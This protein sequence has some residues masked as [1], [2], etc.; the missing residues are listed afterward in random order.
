M[1]H[2]FQIRGIG[3]AE[4]PMLEGWTTLGF[5]AANTS[6][7]R[8]GLMVG[9]IHYRLPGLW[10]K[11]AT[12][13]DVLSGGRA[14]LGIGAAW[15]QDESDALGFPMPPLG[16][17]F[18]MPEETLQIAQAMWSGD[19][20]TQAPFAGAQFTA[21]RL[22]N[23]PQSISRPR[24]PIMIGGGG[25][26]KTLRLVAQYADTTNVFGGPELLAHKYAILREHCEAIGRPYGEIE[27]STLQNTRLSAS[28]G[29]GM[30]SPEAAA[31]RFAP[32]A[33][34]G[35]HKLIDPVPDDTLRRLLGLASVR[36]RAILLLLL[37]TGLRVF[38]AAGIRL[39][40]LRPDGSV[41][42]MGMGAK[43]QIVPIGSTARGAIV[44]YLG[45]RGPGAPDAPLFLGRRGALDWRGM[46]Q[47]LK[48]LK[49]R[50][51]ITGRCSP[52][53][54]RHTFARSYLVNGGDVFS[55]QQILGHTTLDMV[56][57]YVSL[58][59]ADVAAKHRVASPADRL[60]E[61]KGR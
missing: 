55:L 40:D 1:D 7:A 33:G 51:G 27:R 37:D 35:A 18:E 19:R 14:W 45:Q 52:H 10:V 4:D 60:L 57:R 42:V 9:G 47:V 6:H 8:L 28:G 49:T 50:A 25:E 54:L 2:F 36:D 29:E 12:T 13:L 11:A 41:K 5:M 61:T 38:E 16:T 58:A 3:P 34:A 30:E 43:E 15:N 31:A 32:L 23:S 26:E 56:K 44:R 20:G 48:R 22:L 17:R 24:V 21:G 39:G 46:Q 59:D 53:S